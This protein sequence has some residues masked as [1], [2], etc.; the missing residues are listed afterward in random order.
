M[1]TK[2]FTAVIAVLCT[3]S[4]FAQISIMHNFDGSSNEGAYPTGSL[5]NING[6]FYGISFNPGVVFKI[7]SDGTGFTKLLEFGFDS[8]GSGPRGSLSYD[9][10]FLYGMTSQGGT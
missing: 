10:T 3:L 8:D 4:S 7:N 2:L 9:G 5:I 6:V 1:K